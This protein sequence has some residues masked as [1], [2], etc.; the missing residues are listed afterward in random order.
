MSVALVRPD[1]PWM[2]LGSFGF[3][4]CVRVRV[5][6][7]LVRSGSSA[8][9]GRAL[10][11]SRFV[12]VKLV[13]PSVPQV[14]F[15]FVCIVRVRPCGRWVCRQVRLRPPGVSLGS[16]AY[17]WYVRV[18]LGRR[19]IDPYGLVLFVRMR[20]WGRWVRFGS[21]CSFACAMGVAGFV[22]V[23][24]VRPGV[25]LGSFHS[26]RCALGVSS[27]VM[28]CLDCLCAPWGSLSSLRFVWFAWARTGDIW[29]R[30]GSS[31][32]SGC[33]MVVAGFV[34]VGL[35]RPSAPWWSL[36]SFGFVCFV[37]V[38]PSGRWIRSGSGLSGCVLGIFVV[39]LVPS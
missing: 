12:Q 7:R 9:S 37:G 6:G 39:F 14:S 19:Y 15:G 4:W 36:G 25:S 8:L 22:R 32:S 2:S 18:R 29:L 24:L 21:S 26:N 11:I 30:S 28:V 27:F 17:V 34:F 35:V 31:G 1:A 13:R 38:R 3:D 10:E 5:G 20:P 33:T 16:F 23:R